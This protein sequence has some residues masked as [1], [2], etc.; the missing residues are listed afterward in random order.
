MGRSVTFVPHILFFFAVFYVFGVVFMQHAWIGGG[1]GFARGVQC[2]C[3]ADLAFWE[4]ERRKERLF[5]KDWMK[6]VD[7]YGMADMVLS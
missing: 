3:S 4:Q 1:G 2:S 7:S 6:I 5:W